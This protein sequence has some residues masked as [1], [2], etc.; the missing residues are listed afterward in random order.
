MPLLP[1]GTRMVQGPR[2]GRREP[3]LIAVHESGPVRVLAERDP[4][5]DQRDGQHSRFPGTAGT[6]VEAVVAR[7]EP[8]RHS[9]P[10]QSRVLRI[11]VE[12][13]GGETVVD[14]AGV[15]VQAT[16][17]DLHRMIAFVGDVRLGQTR[18]EGP[19]PC[20][21]LG[22]VQ[23]V[24]VAGVGVHGDELRGDAALGEKPIQ[25]VLGIRPPRF[26]LLLAGG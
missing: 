18:I 4:H 6:L 21:L 26:L 12:G 10:V 20:D 9:L 1:D 23:P 25:R 11:A 24:R 13:G 17:R 16:E 7:P 3:T 14:D 15:G 2:P 22:R 8:H 5:G 19:G